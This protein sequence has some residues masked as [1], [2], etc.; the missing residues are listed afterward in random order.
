MP[1]INPRCKRFNWQLGTTVALLLG[2]VVLLSNP[3]SAG[4]CSI[5]TFFFAPV[6]LFA[7]VFVPIAIRVFCEEQPVRDLSAFRSVL[8]QRPPPASK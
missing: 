7:F 6:F 1:K 2:L 8:F 5:H 4:I 3:V